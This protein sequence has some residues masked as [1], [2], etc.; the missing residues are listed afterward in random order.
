MDAILIEVI[1][2]LFLIVAVLLTFLILLQ[3]GNGGGLASLGGTKAPE[4]V[5]VANPIRRAT[6]VL[7]ILF[8][9]VATILGILAC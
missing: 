3:E 6:V 9:V 8:F 5:G 2:G 1:K 7:A 4:I